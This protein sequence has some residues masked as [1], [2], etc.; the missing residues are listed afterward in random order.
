M[1]YASAAQAGYMRR[2]KNTG[3]YPFPKSSVPGVRVGRYSANTKN[4][5][6]DNVSGQQ[7]EGSGWGNPPQ[8][9]MDAETKEQRRYEDSKELA[10]RD[11]DLKET[12][13]LVK[14]NREQTD[15]DRAFSKDKEKE[16]RMEAFRAVAMGFAARDPQL[17]E[18]GIRGLLPQ[19]KDLDVKK[20]KGGVMRIQD[21]RTTK[22]I[23]RFEFDP[24]PNGPVRVFFPGQEEPATFKNSDEAFAAFAPLNPAFEMDKEMERRH[25]KDVAEVSAQGRAKQKDVDYDAAQKFAT[26][27]STTYDQMG[28]P[29]VDQAAYDEAYQE[30]IRMQTGGKPDLG[31]APPV[32]GARKAPDGNWYIQDDQ[33]QYRP[34]IMKGGYQG[35]GEPQGPPDQ[36]QPAGPPLKAA[37]TQQQPGPAPAPA[38]GPAPAM[39]RTEPAQE[40]QP[41]PRGKWT[42]APSDEAKL[43]GLQELGIAPENWKAAAQEIAMAAGFTYDELLGKPWREIM[44]LAQQYFQSQKGAMQRLP[45]YGG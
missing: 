20:G 6:P 34:V 21:P 17:A 28:N 14:R 12:E 43:Q 40:A 5:E 24:D 38:G 44:S 2:R 29:I 1:S 15:R 23:P 42:E 35:K 22:M 10:Y 33:G 39:Q 8:E 25:E 16:D 18:Q 27:K 31:E 11:Q 9:Q 45:A 7:G 19:P 32:E 36:R 41:T 4:A 30:H 26:D 3:N 13:S 37:H